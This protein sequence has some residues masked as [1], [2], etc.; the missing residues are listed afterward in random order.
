MKTLY[1]SILSSTNTGIRAV[2]LKWLRDN[3]MDNTNANC[4][5]IK[6][7]EILCN[8]KRRIGQVMRLKSDMPSRLSFGDMPDVSLSIDGFEH[9]SSSQLPKNI[10]YITIKTN[11][12][13]INDI[14]ICVG[15]FFSII[16][17]ENLSKLNNINVDFKF[18]GMF[19]E[20]SKIIR[21]NNHILLTDNPKL[22]L[23]EINNIHS[24][25][26]TMIGLDDTIASKQLRKEISDK[27]GE[28]I[29]EVINKY[30]SKMPKLRYITLSKRVRLTRY[31][32]H[33]NKI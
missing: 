11:D 33:W 18:P 2:M 23:A 16:L 13:S 4:F 30:F 27:T 14:N 21:H 26:C 29:D 31:N 5:E 22:G 25:E 28:E 1:E 17:S 3:M 9:M 8:T 12:D 20:K 19:D 10:D 7:N 15:Q 6:D 32:T 24:P